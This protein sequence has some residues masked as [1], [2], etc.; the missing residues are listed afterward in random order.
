MGVEVASAGIKSDSSLVSLAGMNSL[1][2][3]KAKGRI[4]SVGRILRAVRR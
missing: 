1:S 2:L 3:M 4:I